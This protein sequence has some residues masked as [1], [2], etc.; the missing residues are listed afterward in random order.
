LFPFD[1]A[2]EFCLDYIFCHG[3]QGIKVISA[4]ATAAGILT[5]CTT[6]NCTKVI[7]AIGMQNTIM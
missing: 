4:L 7:R 3:T 6:V 1:D 5:N 2:K